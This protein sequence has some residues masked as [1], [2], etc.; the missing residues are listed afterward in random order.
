[1]H[2]R[3]LDET[4]KALDIVDN[5][6][7]A[8]FTERLELTKDVVAYKMK[9]G[10]AV[11]DPVREQQKL[12]ALTKDIENDFTSQGVRELF[13]QIMAIGKKLQYQILC[14]NGKGGEIP[15]TPVPELK[16]QGVKVVYQGVEGAY[17]NA[18]VIQFFGKEAEGYGVSTFAAAMEEVAEGRA[19]YGVLPIENSRAGAVGDVYDLLMKYDNT[20]VAETYVKVEHCLLGLPGASL[21]QI[22]TVYSHPQ[23]LMQCAGFLEQH[24]DWQQVGQSNTAVSAK[25]V[26]SEGDLARAAIASELA[27]ELYGLQ[28]LQRGIS[29]D[30][31]NT[32]RFIIVQKR[33]EFLQDARKISLCVE[34]EHV[35]GALYNQLSH[36]IFN[37]LNMTKIE[38]RPIPDRAWE[39]RFYIDFEGNLSDPAVKN[40]LVGLENEAGRLKILGNYTALH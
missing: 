37:S 2:M 30:K 10:K 5:Q 26:V 6:I 13:T 18:A 23:G 9:V 15:F 33:K 27:G 4:R 38:S 14:E 8:L 25:K 22:Q 17:G 3:S 32:T 12:D 7:K 29:D 24:R 31:N 20:I 11:L 35:S 40:A 21:D 34:T 1:M 19:D 39:Y 36:F 16:T 28:V